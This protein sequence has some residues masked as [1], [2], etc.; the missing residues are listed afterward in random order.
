MAVNNPTTRIER[1]QAASRKGEKYLKKRFFALKSEGCKSDTDKG[2][3]R[4][5]LIDGEAPDI[6]GCEFDIDEDKLRRV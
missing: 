3:L 5:S 4:S 1:T 2:E 6:R